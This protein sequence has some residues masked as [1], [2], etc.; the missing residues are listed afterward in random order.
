MPDWSRLVKDIKK[1]AASSAHAV[2]ST[3]EKKALE[4]ETHAMKRWER[5]Q[6]NIGTNSV[7]ELPQ[8]INGKNT[9]LH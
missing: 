9:T 6:K 7:E 8:E 5:Y 3:A 4:R 2:W 1:Y